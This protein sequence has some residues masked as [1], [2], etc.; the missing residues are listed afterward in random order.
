MKKFKDYKLETALELN[1]QDTLAS[2]REKFI[3][4]DEK[5]IYLDGNSL[6]RLPRATI[7]H[8]D[9][10]IQHEWGSRLIRSWN[11]GWYERSNRIGAKI[12]ALIGAH[13]DEV[14]LSDSTSVNLYKLAHAAIRHAAPRKKVVSDVFNFPSDLYVL[15][16][17]IEQLG[18]THHLDLIPSRDNVVIHLE[19]VRKVIDKETALVSLSHVSFKSAFLY[20]MQKITRI[21]HNK[22]ALILW[23]LSHS[24]GVVPIHLNQSDVDLAVGC[25]YKYL[26]GGPGAPAF[27]YVRKELQQKLFS[28]IWGWFGDQKPFDFRLQY[29]PAKSLKRFMAGTPPILSL[30]ALE[31]SLDIIHDAGLS[32]IREK[33]IR[34]TEY[35]IFLIKELLEPQGFTLGTPLSHKVRGSHVSLRHPEAFRICQAL[36]HPDGSEFIIIPDFR[37]PDHIRLGLSPLYTSYSDIFYAIRI[38]KDIVKEKKFE[39]FD[40]ARQ[41]V[42]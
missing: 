2:Y 31:P 26:N 3:V 22:G 27:L 19:E 23:D 1:R 6:G 36:I 17:I 34:Q 40:S 42:T 13:P 14:I 32:K 41:Q 29:Q 21:A 11:E 16:G 25:T 5:V 8:L 20:D 9:R 37:E 7:N 10:V 4:S 15:Q 30:T 24:A 38:L 18:N 39:K 12:A 28:P 35:M 33:S